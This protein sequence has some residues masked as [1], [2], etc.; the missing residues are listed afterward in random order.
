M[1][2]EAIREGDLVVEDIEEELRAFRDGRA[3]VL[4]VRKAREGEQPSGRVVSVNDVRV[5]I[6]LFQA[7]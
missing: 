1:R 7:R 4:R 6:W 2:G 5:Q 3:P